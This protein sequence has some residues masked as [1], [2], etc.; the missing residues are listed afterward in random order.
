M[1]L[2]AVRMV[3]VGL[4]RRL[5]QKEPFEDSVVAFG[6]NASDSTMR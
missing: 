4:E 3:R 6:K 5:G 1:G 2:V